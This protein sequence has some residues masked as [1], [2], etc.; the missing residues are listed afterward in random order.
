MFCK[1][2]QVNL[3]QLSLKNLVFPLKRN[4]VSSRKANKKFL[5]FS[6]KRAHLPCKTKWPNQ[7]YSSNKVFCLKKLNKAFYDLYLFIYQKQI[8]HYDPFFNETKSI[9]RY[10]CTLY[11]RSLFQMLN[12]QILVDMKFYSNCYFYKLK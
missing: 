7:I 10:H 4:A 11:V 5:L 6:Y 9:V 3:Q 8:R 1:C 12:K 2:L